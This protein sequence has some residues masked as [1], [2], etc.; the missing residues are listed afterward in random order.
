MGGL[1]EGQLHVLHVFEEMWYICPTMSKNLINM[2]MSSNVRIHSMQN[3]IIKN[4]YQSSARQEV[5]VPS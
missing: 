1:L 5:L 3:K 2:C 4:L